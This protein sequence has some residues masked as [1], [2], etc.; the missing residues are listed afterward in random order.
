MVGFVSLW[1]RL[2]ASRRGGGGGTEAHFP[3]PPPSLS[4]V[5]GRLG[6]V[7]G[8][9]GGEVDPNILGSKRSPRRADHC[10]YT[11]VEGTFLVVL[12]Q[13]LCSSAFGAN[14]HS[15]TNQRARHGSPTPGW[16]RVS[17]HVWGW[18]ARRQHNRQHMQSTRGKEWLV[19]SRKTAPGTF[20]KT[21]REM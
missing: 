6:A 2:L 11:F 8:G 21:V 18:W 20:R 16:W 7:R 9:R 10:D 5:A 15:S 13:K 1:R 3:A 17:R 19:K 14:I 4:A 12:G